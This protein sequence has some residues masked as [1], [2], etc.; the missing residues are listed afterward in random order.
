M[1]YL[2]DQMNLCKKEEK[3]ENFTEYITHGSGKT[4]M[5]INQVPYKMSWATKLKFS[6]TILQ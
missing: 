1:L 2:C 4:I 6:S 3:H 5:A